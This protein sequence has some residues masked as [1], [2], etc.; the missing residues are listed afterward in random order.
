MY[1]NATIQQK[2]QD[3]SFGPLLQVHQWRWY[4]DWMTAAT[5]LITQYRSAFVYSNG[6]FPEVYP[7]ESNKSMQVEETS[8]EFCEEIVIP[9]NLK[10]DRAPYFCGQESSYLKLAKGKRNNLTHV[11]P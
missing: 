10:S 8:Q 4:V 11:E 5:K 7:K 9:E 1:R 3:R 2:I 6:T